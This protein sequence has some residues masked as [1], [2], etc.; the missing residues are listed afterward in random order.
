MTTDEAAPGIVTAAAGRPQQWPVQA[1]SE[2]AP[3]P[4][5]CVRDEG[6]ATFGGF[7]AA[8]LKPS[9]KF[10]GG[11]G[12]FIFRLTPAPRAF[13]ASGENGNYVY[14]NAGMD[15][16]PNGLAFGGQIE[17][18]YFGLWLRDDLESGRSCAPCS[19]YHSECVA[20]AADFGVREVEVWAVEDDPPVDED[21]LQDDPLVAAGIL[22][23]KHAETRAFLEMA[24]KSMPSQQAAQGSGS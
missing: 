9:P 10:Q 20:S 14:F 19:T 8:P 21:A 24:G 2:G 3:P 7:W 17:S 18:R 11:F 15:Q 22:A 5:L 13:T 4:R 23:P 1:A 6:C 12:S 16:L